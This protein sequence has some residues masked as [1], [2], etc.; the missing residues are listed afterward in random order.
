MLMIDL[1]FKNEVKNSGLDII[2]ENNN[3]FEIN[4]VH[5]KVNLV[6]EII[7]KIGLKV[8]SDQEIVER[9]ETCLK[10]FKPLPKGWRKNALR[11]TG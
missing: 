7:T 8:P 3:Y 5:P 1:I 2:F 4:W 11:Q 6:N 10:T 9:I